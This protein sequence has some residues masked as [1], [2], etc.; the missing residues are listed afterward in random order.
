MGQFSAEKPVP[1]GDSFAANAITHRLA[2]GA[3]PR[4]DCA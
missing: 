2:L 1:Q 4:D 3:P